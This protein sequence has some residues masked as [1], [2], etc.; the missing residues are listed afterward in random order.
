MNISKKY[1]Q[2]TS[3]FHKIGLS[4]IDTIVYVCLLDKGDLSPTDI[5]KHTD[6]HRPSVYKS[7][8][9][10][11]DLHLIQT[12]SKGKRILYAAESPSK[13]ESVF[14]K[15]EQDFFSEIE[16]LHHMYET[17]TSKLYV[18][19]GSGPDSIRD[20]YSDVVNK[21]ETNGEYYRYSSIDNKK[22]IDKYVPKDYQYTRDKK[23]IERFIITGANNIHKKRLGRTVK[24]MPKE[25]DLFEDSINL[26]IYTDKVSIVDYASESTITITHKK[27]AEFQKKIFKLLFDRL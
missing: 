8:E 20:V 5:T 25:Y 3:T 19:L 6:L 14:K 17:N 26:I 18:S 7:L 22:V 12:T 15:V 27:F 9:K 13:L 2:Y 23:N 4:D 21:T 11:L 24:S 16:D 1:S 10:L